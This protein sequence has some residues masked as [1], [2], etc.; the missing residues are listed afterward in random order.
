M[1]SE[2][3]PSGSWVEFIDER[4]TSQDMAKIV[5]HVPHGLSSWRDTTYLAQIKMERGAD[6]GWYSI[7][8]FVEDKNESAKNS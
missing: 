2:I 6:Y 1:K 8:K 4:T 3:L 5:I 7:V